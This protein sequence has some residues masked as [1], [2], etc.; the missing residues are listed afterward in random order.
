MQNHYMRAVS[1]GPQVGVMGRED[2]GF[3]GIKFKSQP[4]NFSAARDLRQATYPVNFSFCIC[5]IVK[6]TTLP[7]LLL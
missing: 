4:Y 6:H 7:L 2:L 3:D 1:R 5:K